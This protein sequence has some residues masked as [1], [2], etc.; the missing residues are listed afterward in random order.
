[1]TTKEIAKEIR[2]E[3]KRFPYKFSVTA[4]DVYA[5][6]VEPKEDI[7]SDDLERIREICLKYEN[8]KVDE[9]TGEILSGGNTYVFL[10]KDGRSI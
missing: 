8:Y 5:V 7:K 2:K 9:R 10:Q 4:P 1:M 6:Y 3:L